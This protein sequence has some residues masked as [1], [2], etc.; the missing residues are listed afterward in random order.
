MHFLGN[1]VDP[2]IS[3]IKQCQKDEYYVLIY[4][5]ISNGE[6][7]YEFFQHE[8]YTSSL[9]FLTHSKSSAHFT[10]LNLLPECELEGLLLKI[11]Q[12]QIFFINSLTI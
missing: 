6:Y 10:Y 1:I 11:S 5:Y 12:I 7:S 2:F 3:L 9:L 4:K 8:F